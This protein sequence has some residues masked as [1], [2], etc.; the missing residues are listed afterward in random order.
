M[1][2]LAWSAA[3]TSS[4]PPFKAWIEPERV[5]AGKFHHGASKHP[6][7]TTEEDGSCFKHPGFISI[8]FNCC[9]TSL[10]FQNNKLPGCCETELSSWQQQKQ[11]SCK[12]SLR[13]FGGVRRQRPLLEGRRSWRNLNPTTLIR[14]DQLFDSRK[15]ETGNR[16]QD[17]H[18]SS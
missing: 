18:N 10:N 16:K 11:H 12:I 9:L 5:R 8:P 1:L 13:T 6:I 17:C 2:F 14:D 15:Q 3:S 4:P 7:I